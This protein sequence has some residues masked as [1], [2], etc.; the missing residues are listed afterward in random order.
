ML[1]VIVYSQDRGKV[2][3]TKTSMQ[4][5][6]MRSPRCVFNAMTGI[7]ASYLLHRTACMVCFARDGGNG[8]I[9]PNSLSRH[10]YR[11]IHF[12]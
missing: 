9:G 6:R 4:V 3:V 7:C 8:G 1:V 11:A 2:T 5:G 10:A 12:K